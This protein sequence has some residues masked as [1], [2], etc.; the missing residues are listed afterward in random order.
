MVMGAGLLVQAVGISTS[1]LSPALAS[2]S[3]RRVITSAI[4]MEFTKRENA[5]VGWLEIRTDGGRK[6]VGGVCFDAGP[7]GIPNGLAD[8]A[9]LKY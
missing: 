3:L 7:R 1:G 8:L 2:V 9:T 6:D 4:I 5:R